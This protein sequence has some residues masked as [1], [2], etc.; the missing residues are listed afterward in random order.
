M[1]FVLEF[2]NSSFFNEL[3]KLRHDRDYLDIR[4]AHLK[5]EF[6]GLVWRLKPVVLYF[7]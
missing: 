3:I 7:R 1:A 6:H 5:A 2:F 4:C